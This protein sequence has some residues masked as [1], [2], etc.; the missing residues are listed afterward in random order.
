[1]IRS[2]QPAAIDV[3]VPVYNAACFLRETIDSILSQDFS[4]FRLLLSVVIGG[5]GHYGVISLIPRVP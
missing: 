1:M 2:E 3:C 5:T 4:D